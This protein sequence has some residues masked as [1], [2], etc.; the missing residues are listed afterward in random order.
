M[1]KTKSWIQMKIRQL[2][3]T[4][5]NWQ[6]YSMLCVSI[7]PT[8]TFLIICFICVTKKMVLAKGGM[9]TLAICETFHSNI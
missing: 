8:G 4:L 2:V 3:A 6:N 5:E 1:V 7:I 9:Q